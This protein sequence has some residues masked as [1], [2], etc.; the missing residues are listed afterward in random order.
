MPSIHSPNFSLNAFYAGQKEQVQTLL[1]C[2]FAAEDGDITHED[3]T[4]KPSFVIV[5]PRKAEE[6]LGAFLQSQAANPLLSA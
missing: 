3:G 6:V 1:N 5:S 2:T 4:S